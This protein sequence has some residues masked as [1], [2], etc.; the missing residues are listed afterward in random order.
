MQL[1]QCDICNLLPK[2]NPIFETN[3]WTILINK[4]Q[5]YLGRCYVTLKKHKG[6]LSEINDDEWLDFSE[7]VSKLE[8]ALKKVFGVENFNWTSLMNNAYQVDNAK[9]HI[10]WHVIPRY[11]DSITF[12]G[13]KFSD[14]QFGHHYNRDQ[15]LNVEE[16]VLASIKKAIQDNLD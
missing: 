16:A 8:T 4:N 6:S 15:R 1:T 2:L 11:K 9:P 13:I 5:G 3:N 14:P 10:H 12:N 7:V